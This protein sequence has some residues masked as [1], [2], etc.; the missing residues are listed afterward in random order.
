MFIER[1]FDAAKT[2]LMLWTLWWNCYHGFDVGNYNGFHV[3]SSVDCTT[4]SVCSGGI[5][6]PVSV[7]CVSSVKVWIG[8][9]RMEDNGMG[10]GLPAVRPRHVVVSSAGRCYMLRSSEKVLGVDYK[11]FMLERSLITYFKK[12]PRETSLIAA[13]TLST[14]SCVS[15]WTNMQTHYH[16]ECA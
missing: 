10:N 9:G 5:A 15:V 11:V 4:S 8:W 2:E 13:G 12:G 16:I 6:A 3:N 14:W 7:C 1:G